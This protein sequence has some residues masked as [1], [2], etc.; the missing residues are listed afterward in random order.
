METTLYYLPELA[1]KVFTIEND[2][3]AAAPARVEG[4]V[5][6]LSCR[7]RSSCCLM[8]TVSWDVALNYGSPRFQ[9]DMTHRTLEKSFFP[10]MLPLETRR[11]LICRCAVCILPISPSSPTHF[12]SCEHE[13]FL[14]KMFL[15]WLLT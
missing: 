1:S 4:L 13:H 11:H 10:Y 7:T 9:E 8:E 2:S 5:L 3:F 12:Y 15:V 14:F 6:L